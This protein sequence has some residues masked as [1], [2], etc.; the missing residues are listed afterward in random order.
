MAVAVMMEVVDVGT[1]KPGEEV[2]V[3]RDGRRRAKDV[4]FLRSSL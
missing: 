2:K 1:A 4:N 3:E